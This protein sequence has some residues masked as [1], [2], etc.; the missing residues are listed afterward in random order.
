[1]SP[2]ARF[3]FLSL[4]AS[5]TA[6]A[7]A[8]Q[9]GSGHFKLVQPIVEL[10]LPLTA[11]NF[12]PTLT[13]DELTMVFASNRPGGLGGFDLYETT[14]ADVVSP[15]GAPVPLAG[16]NSA[17]DEYEP[18]LS[19]TGLELYLVSDRSGRI[20][21]Y[22]LWVSTRASVSQ[23]WGAPQNLG[24]PVNGNGLTN[25]DPHLTEDGLTLFFTS[26][27]PN[28]VAHIHTVT[29]TAIG[30]P[31]G[32]R[33]QFLPTSS[34]NYDHSPIPEANGNIVWFGSSRAAGT[35]SSD[36]YVTWRL[37]G[38]T[39]WAVPVEIK[40]LN[41]DGWESNGFRGGITQT[42]Y[43]SRSGN[44]S[45]SQ[46]M[47]GCSRFPL[48]FNPDRG[49]YDVLATHITLQPVPRTVWNRVGDAPIG[50]LTRLRWFLCEPPLNPT[51]LVVLGG[52]GLLPSGAVLPRFEN[53]FLLLPVPLLTVG[54]FPIPADRVNRLDL[55]IP[56][57]PALVG[58][59]L[60][61]QSIHI[62]VF[63]Y[64]GAFSEPTGLHFR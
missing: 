27:L 64:S 5:L 10:N 3:L 35:G 13:L 2:R 30:Q 49:P 7:S 33:Q 6:G 8:A 31:W 40:E 23:P 16:L 52:L 50:Q 22:D 25:E 47:T 48:A 28:S 62:D 46:L 17:F 42:F 4:A 59:V 19:F 45:T 9:E 21:A 56:N 15:W 37:P 63:G 51:I 61:I 11:E 36:W 34:P 60:Q 43:F 32:N 29:R 54:V 38:T 14:R 58:N 57:D 26:V 18:H 44:G 12:S 41:T 24:V 20:G 1:M 53:E 55:A 39:T